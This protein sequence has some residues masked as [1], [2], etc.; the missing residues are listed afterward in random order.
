M[1]YSLWT[2]LLPISSLVNWHWTLNSITLH[3]FSTWKLRGCLDWTKHLLALVISHVTY[4]RDLRRFIYV[5]NRTW[6][7]VLRAWQLDFKYTFDWNYKQKSR[8]SPTP[9]Q[10]NLALVT[11]LISSCP[12]SFSIQPADLVFPLTCLTVRKTT[13]T[14]KEKKKG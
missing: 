14:E 12:W 13:K 1:V 4:H 10:D 9:L 8:E 11:C 2:R 6:K 3:D 7:H 5:L